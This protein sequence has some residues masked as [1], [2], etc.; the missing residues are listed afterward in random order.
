MHSYSE[1]K[2]KKKKKK[3]KN[4]YIYIAEPIMHDRAG[5]AYIDRA[6]PVYF[7]VQPWPK[8]QIKFEPYTL[9]CYFVAYADSEG[10]IRLRIRA[11]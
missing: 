8:D 3:K 7:V 2:K 10:P 11:V 6:R 5:S 9:K 4:I 1:K